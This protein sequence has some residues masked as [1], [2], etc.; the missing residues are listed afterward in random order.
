MTNVLKID[1]LGGNCP[2]QSEGTING[3]EFYF[4]ARGNSWRFSVG[5][6]VILNPLWETSDFWGDNPYAA[7]FMT[8]EEAFSIIVASA[9][10]Y[11]KGDI[12]IQYGSPVP[13][14]SEKY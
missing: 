8:A 10:L 11:V 6:D 7:G 1:L 5:G 12:E 14:D 3:E 13:F 9:K 4:R 2:V